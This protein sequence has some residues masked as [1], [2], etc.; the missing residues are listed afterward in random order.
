MAKENKWHY[1]HS[2]HET[3]KRQRYRWKKQ[4][5]LYQN[6]QTRVNKNCYESGEGG[7]RGS[8]VS[9]QNRIGNL[10]FRCTP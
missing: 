6:S 1:I 10:N 5:T 7:K 4:Q 2:G 8:F 3:M 9:P